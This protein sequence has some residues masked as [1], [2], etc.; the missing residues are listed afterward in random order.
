MTNII[1]SLLITTALLASV[2]TG[3][4]RSLRQLP[5][6]AKVSM[7]EVHRYGIEKCFTAEPVGQT[8]FSRMKGKSYK[9][10]CTVPLSD[11]RY[12]RLLHYNKNGEIMTGELVCNRRI[13]SD[14]LKIFR[15][16]FDIRYPIERMELIDNYGADDERSMAA[17]NSSC[18]NYRPMTG[19]R[20]LSLHSRG[21]AIDINTLYNPYVKTARNGRTVVKPAAG[22]P[23]ADRSR[24]FAYKIDHNDPAYKIFRQYGFRWGG[25]WHSLKDYQHFEKKL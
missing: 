23:Y 20:S 10:G 18:F 21:L 16:L 6:G 1:H 13:A 25:D 11:L 17:N 5:A 7:E 22:R 2:V 12:V 19:G 9:D 14:V 24:R 3:A 15:R 8:V 4:A